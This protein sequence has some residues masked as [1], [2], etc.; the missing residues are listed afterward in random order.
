MLLGERLLQD[1]ECTVVKEVL[2]KLLP[3]VELNAVAMYSQI[4]A[5]TQG[6][7]VHAAGG[8]AVW[9]GRRAQAEPVL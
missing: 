1:A 7:A 9:I 2:Q 6:G 5:L 3:R 8:P 4:H